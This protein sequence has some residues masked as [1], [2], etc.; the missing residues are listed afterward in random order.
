MRRLK[1]TA[2][3]FL[4]T[5]VIL[6]SCK[7]EDYLIN[8]MYENNNIVLSGAQEVPANPSTATGSVQASYNQATKTLTYKVIWSGLS[9]NAT[10]GHIH[11]TGG[12]GVIAGAIQ[13]F[14]GLSLTAAG[15]FGGTVFMD[16][17]KFKEE[18][19]LAGLYY[20]N[21]HTTLYTG[22]EI[23]GQIVLNKK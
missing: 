2:F 16:G 11:G 19:L 3:S 21:I 14:T 4:I 23:R 6:F 18:E 5:S 12:P 15:S 20:V 17:L 9:G 10:M 13:T 8:H 22:G 1:L 7:Q